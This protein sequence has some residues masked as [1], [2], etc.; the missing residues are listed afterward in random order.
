[1]A[2]QIRI[3]GQSHNS[4]NKM[5]SA[6]KSGGG[7]KG[8]IPYIPAGDGIV[9]RLLAE[10][11]DGWYEY[12]EHFDPGL[13]TSY[14]CI[15]GSCPGCEQGLDQSKKWLIPVVDRSTDKAIA[16]K[17]PQSVVSKLV[18]KYDKRETI[19]DRDYELSKMGTGFDTEYDVEAGDAT[20]FVPGKYDMPDLEQAIQ[21]SWEAAFA[22]AHDSDDDEDDEV[23]FATPPRRV[24]PKAD[25]VKKR[26]P[27]RDTET[28]SSTRTVRRR[29]R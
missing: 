26:R 10:P 29:P 15:E 6:M 18:M 11:G 4:L 14:P 2:K 1:M 27:S 8:F 25:A 28:S 19:M 20:K 5:R 3:K 16:L 7:G 12:R 22:D 17:V 13:R 23:D 9:V 21:D 24:K